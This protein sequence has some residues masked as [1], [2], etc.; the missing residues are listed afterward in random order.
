VSI[1]NYLSEYLYERNYALT[2][3]SSAIEHNC[4]HPVRFQFSNIK[5]TI[6]NLIK[7]IKSYQPHAVIFFVNLKNPYLFPLI[8]YCK[9]HGIRVLYWGHGRDLSDQN[10]AIK[11]VLYMLEHSLSDSIVLYAE[12]L[13]THIATWNRK[14]IFIAN[15]TLNLSDISRPDVDKTLVFDKYGIHT[16]KNILFVGRLQR[17]KKL[18]DLLQAHALMALDNVGLVIV[19]PSEDADVEVGGYKNVYKLGPVYGDSLFELMAAM[20]VY[21]MPGWVGLSIVDAFFMGLPLVTQEGDHPPE[22]GYLRHGEN[23]YMVPAG[24]L[25]TMARVLDQIL[26]DDQLRTRLSLNATQT[27]RC[28]AHI[29]IMCEGFYRALNHAT[30]DIS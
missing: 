30:G 17:R 9:T 6:G 1:Y 10:S 22:I 11:N 27:Y 23:G 14:K 29:D 16:Q 25:D 7:E 13:K 26:E 4:T 19:G 18:G 5:L 2:V 20:D 28:K 12:H 24:D 8:V 3:L 15:N 21:C